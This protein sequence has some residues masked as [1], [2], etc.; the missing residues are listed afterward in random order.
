MYSLNTKAMKKTISILLN[1]LSLALIC[2]SINAPHLLVMFLFAGEIPFTNIVLS[3]TQ[4]MAMMIVLA[5]I[6]FISSVVPPIIRKIRINKK[7]TSRIS[8]KLTRAR[9]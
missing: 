5:I 1:V 4:M 6:L 7:Q 9:A 3:A 2:D 8:H